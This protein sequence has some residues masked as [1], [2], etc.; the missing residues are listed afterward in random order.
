ML[1]HYKAGNKANI[2]MQLWQFAHFTLA[3]HVVVPSPPPVSCSCS[4]CYSPPLLGL[5]DFLFSCCLHLLHL[6][7]AFQVLRDA[8]W[9]AVLFHQNLLAVRICSPH[10]VPWG[11]HLLLKSLEFLFSFLFLETLFN[12]AVNFNT[13]QYPLFPPCVIPSRITLIFQT[14]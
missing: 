8:L 5:E 14:S 6:T 3:P 2:K 4:R 11:E 1:G 12:A 10:Q 9:S 13:A 7:C